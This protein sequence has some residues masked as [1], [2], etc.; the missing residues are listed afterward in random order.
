MTECFFLYLAT[1]MSNPQYTSP[2]DD[3][4]FEMYVDKDVA[5]IMRLM[6]NKKHQA[7]IG[8]KV[9]NYN[10]FKRYNSPSSRFKDFN[11]CFSMYKIV[12]PRLN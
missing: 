2:Y 9:E 1:M 5:R 4:A 6:E 7:V 10:Y 11:R 3:L 8:T 12:K